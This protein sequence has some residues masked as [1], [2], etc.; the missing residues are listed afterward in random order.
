MKLFLL[1]LPPNAAAWYFWPPQTC[2]ATSRGWWIL[3]IER[4]FSVTRGETARALDAQCP[5][6]PCWP[7]LQSGWT[8]LLSVPWATSN[9]WHKLLSPSL[10]NTLFM[11][12][13]A[14]C[15]SLGRCNRIPLTGRLK[16]HTFI[17][18][19][20]GDRKSKIRVPAWLGSGKS[21]LLVC[22]WPCSCCGLTWQ[23]VE[24]EGD[25]MSLPFTSGAF[26]PFVRTSSSQPKSSQRPHLQVPSQ[27]GL[28]FNIWISVCNTIIFSWFCSLASPLQSLL[29][30]APDLP[31]L[32]TVQTP[33]FNVLSPPLLSYT[34][35]PGGLTSFMVL[36]S[37]DM[38]YLCGS[39]L[40]ITPLSG[41]QIHL[42]N[43][44]LTIPIR[45]L[46]VI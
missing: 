21:A 28:G 16:Q 6:D 26:I 2:H 7:L 17:S 12:F 44:Y 14:T 25:P 3:G 34:S 41:T 40:Q 37:I 9:V 46:K 27:W 30:V 11:W 42:P 8:V 36:N 29:L 33:G 19:P 24:K 18:P 38:Q 45:R 4:V 20:S 10:S 22:S 15:F 31:D 5:L 39:Y 23:T 43:F 1:S 13:L 35:S 32:S